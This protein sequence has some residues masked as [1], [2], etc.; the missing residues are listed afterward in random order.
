MHLFELSVSYDTI[1]TLLPGRLCN[2]KHGKCIED[3]SFLDAVVQL[4]I[5]LERRCLINFEQPR[6]SIGVYQDIE[7]E[8]FET[9]IKGAIIWLACTIVVKKV[10]LH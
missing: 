7:A 10:R 9:H 5:C 6:L 3:H 8:Y 1:E 2:T 4:A